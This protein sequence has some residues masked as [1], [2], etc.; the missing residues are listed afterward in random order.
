MVSYRVTPDQL[1][2]TFSAALRPDTDDWQ[3]PMA[4]GETWEEV[5]DGLTYTHT[6]FELPALNTHDENDLNLKLGQAPAR[7]TFTT[8]KL[9]VGVY[10]EADD[11]AGFSDFQ[12]RVSHGDH[13]PA[14]DVAKGVERLGHGRGVGSQRP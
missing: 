11:V 13:R 6:G 8:Q 9:T 2:A 10:R 3:Q 14:A 5:G 1:P 12:S 4:M 7:V